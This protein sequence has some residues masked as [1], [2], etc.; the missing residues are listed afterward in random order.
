MA[1]NPLILD[2]QNLQ[3]LP[4]PAQPMLSMPQGPLPIPPTAQPVVTRAVPPEVQNSQGSVLGAQNELQRLQTTGSGIGQIKNPFL[5]GLARVGETIETGLTPGFAAAT[6]GTAMHNQE[7]QMQQQGKINE[8]LKNQQ[9]EA[10]TQQEQALTDYTQQRPDIEEAKVEQRLNAVKDR[11]SQAAAARGQTVDWSDPANPKFQD[12]PTSQAYADHQALSAMHQATA[13]KSAIMADIAKNHYIPGTP[14]FAEAQRKLAQ[15]DKRLGVA[16][17]SLGLRAQ[18]LEL[19]KENQAASLHGTDVNGNPLPGAPQIEGD[20]GELSTIGTKFAPTAIKQQKTVTSFNDLSGSVQHLRQAIKA[21][22]SEGG[23]MSDARLAQAASDPT[24]VIG[25]VING[26]LVTG[27]LS[28]AAIDL[29]NAQRQTMEQAGI[30]RSTTGGTSSEAGAQRIL[31]VVP[32]FGVDTNK[33]AYNK[34]D[35]QEGVLK[36]LAPGQTRVVGGA[37]VRNSTAG[38]GTYQQTATG[39]GGHKIGSNDGVNWFDIQTGKAVQ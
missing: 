37:S 38:R 34:L 15:V 9:S 23:D 8:G 27:G 18:G 13:D 10:Q 6:P 28:P 35:E 19:R 26:K 20:N 31:Q 21:Y 2:Y 14:E 36:R 1:S 39:P 30:L 22:E 24:S 4:V 3:R 33:S 16:M 5:R 25:K 7:L 11:V 17:A 32:Q 29:L 12:D